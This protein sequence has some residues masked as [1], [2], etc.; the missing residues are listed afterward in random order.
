MF[1]ENLTFDDVS[2]VPQYSE[3]ASRHDVDLSCGAHFGLNMTTPILSANMA[4]VTGDEMCRA[5][6]EVG[7][8]GVQH[9]FQSLEDFEVPLNY[10]KIVSIGVDNFV[11]RLNFYRKNRMKLLCIDVAHGHHKKVGDM[12]KHIRFHHKDFFTIIAGNVC[13]TFGGRMVLI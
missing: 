5:M 12:L 6:L 13:T 3:I 9:R 8:V 1:I 10:D 7:G 2:L 11:K 4:T